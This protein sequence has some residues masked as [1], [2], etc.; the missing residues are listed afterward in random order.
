[1]GRSKAEVVN[2][3]LTRVVVFSKPLITPYIYPTLNWF[4]LSQLGEVS[5]LVIKV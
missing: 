2:I 4:R 5:P 3:A 1:M